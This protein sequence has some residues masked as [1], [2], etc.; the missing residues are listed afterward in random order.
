[1]I[2]FMA[3]QLL[4][5]QVLNEPETLQFDLVVASNN[6][7]GMT[8][9]HIP[10]KWEGATSKWNAKQCMLLIASSRSK[11]RRFNNSNY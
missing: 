7:K 3:R 8:T 6:R 5:L 4:F 2:Q 9:T 11:S 1:M 10:S